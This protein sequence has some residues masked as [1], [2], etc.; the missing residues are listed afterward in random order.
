MEMTQF[1]LS[2]GAVW[3]RLLLTASLLTAIAPAGCAIES[4]PGLYPVA[5]R[6]IEG[7]PDISRGPWGDPSVSGVVLPEGPA[8]LAGGSLLALNGTRLEEQVR[9]SSEY[10]A[11]T[12]AERSWILPRELQ[13]WD[14]AI[15][16]VR[17][18][19]EDIGQDGNTD[20]H[21]ELV[22]V[23]IT[24]DGMATE[25]L[26]EAPRIDEVL[27]VPGDDSA[28]VMVVTSG[29]DEL[30]G[31]QRWLSTLRITPGGLR[32]M[33]S[34]Q[35][36]Y[37]L[38]LLVADSP[39]GA[40]IGALISPTQIDKGQHD[41]ELRVLGPDG[42]LRWAASV[43]GIGLIGAYRDSG[44]YGW[45]VDTTT[46]PG[47]DEWD[48]ELTLLTEISAERFELDHGAHWF[49]AT[50]DLDAGSLGDEILMMRDPL[51]E[52][53]RWEPSLIVGTLADGRVEELHTVAEWDQRVRGVT[54]ADINGD[55]LT[56]IVVVVDTEPHVYKSA[57]LGRVEVFL[58]SGD[59]FGP[60]LVSPVYDTITSLDLI[61]LDGD[62]VLEVLLAYVEHPEEADG[63]R[64]SYVD[65]LKVK[66]G[67]R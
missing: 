48:R 52:P 30:S 36:D 17:E 9:F 59:G 25:V 67:P 5:S 29:D 18:V 34:E 31:W 13:P 44:E 63:G 7:Y 16:M 46:M 37:H 33:A 65:V 11:I 55:G 23:D 51:V 47:P 21:R 66:Q 57:Y 42:S 28:T 61:D 35:V 50:G 56:D 39:D 27:V 2:R 60:P 58:N 41:H 3:L 64:T 53:G 22:L 40:T 26:L 54:L 24:G 62:G 1:G 43:P 38:S 8:I 14:G 45:L 19:S 12:A 10:Q 20:T 49:I 15:F 4:E 32:E 6:V